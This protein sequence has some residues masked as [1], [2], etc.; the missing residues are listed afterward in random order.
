MVVKINKSRPTSILPLSPLI[1]VAVVH[2]SAWPS[3]SVETLSIVPSSYFTLSGRL[4]IAISFFLNSDS[5]TIALDNALSTW[6]RDVISLKGDREE[7]LE[8]IRDY[9]YTIKGKKDITTLVQEYF[10]V[11]GYDFDSD[12]EEDDFEDEEW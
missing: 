6:G 12:D 3:S 11:N 7:M 9:L 8:A 1:H 4:G 10:K 5:I 2:I